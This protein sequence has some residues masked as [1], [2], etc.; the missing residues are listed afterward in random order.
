M[1]KKKNKG[2]SIVEIL[3]SVTI[4]AILMIPIVSGIVSS[5]K[6]STSAK[7]LQYRN[8]F[9]ENMME[10]VK[11]DS[12]ENIIT[13]KYFDSIGVYNT[14]KKGAFY[15]E[16]MT[17]GYDA[18]LKGIASVLGSSNVSSTK[19]EQYFTDPSTGAETYYPYE[20]YDF[21]G[22]VKLGTKHTPYV[23]NIEV[24]NEYYAQKQKVTTEAGGKYVNPNNLA[25]GVVEDI[26]YTKIAL[27]NGTIANYD[28]AVTEAY[29]TRK[30]EALKKYAP[31]QYQVFMNQAQGGDFFQK[32]SATRMIAIVVKGS[33]DAGYTVEC[34]LI[35]HDNN[36]SGKLSDPQNSNQSYLKEDYIEY[37]PFTYNYDPVI[38]G[39]EIV[40]K[41]FLPNIYLMYNVCLYNGVYSADDYI[42][43]D[44]SGVTD[45]TPV[46]LF[47]VQTA[48][49]Y[50]NT[51]LSGDASLSSQA[52]KASTAAAVNKGKHTLYN[53]NITDDTITHDTVRV[54]MI[55]TSGSHLNNLSVYHNLEDTVGSTGDQKNY[56]FEQGT[57]LTGKN[58]AGYMISTDATTGALDFY[59][60]P[61]SSTAWTYKALVGS[62]S[63][64]A[65]VDSLN[66][67][68][69]ESRGL[70]RVKIW[71]EEGSD[72]SKI[73]KTK[74]P[75]ITG[76]KGGNES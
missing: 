23:Y 72:P 24:S 26:D 25:L 28:S 70:Y 22:T 66:A 63:G 7:D 43:V 36:E 6:N 17:K 50:S 56:L 45:D 65:T 4:F 20:K 15:V 1:F 52:Y 44:T 35:Y 34:R 13:G 3:I 73:D 57:T 31:G 51:L 14:G 67:A 29:L 55:A 19:S 75:I 61:G 46:N 68:K 37:K 69:E 42:V 49:T 71:M 76:T 62:G 58:N 47:I 54:H 30:A 64:N 12:L 16:D 5:L 53:S 39:G 21:S 59:K 48:E 9:A 40:E 27:I 10:Y 74:D 32:D 8:D 2:F 60:Y 41:A 11:Q 38:E 18:N 33:E